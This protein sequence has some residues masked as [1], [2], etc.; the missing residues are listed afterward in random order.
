MSI[1]DPLRGK[2]GGQS[3]QNREGFFLG[4]NACLRQLLVN[5]AL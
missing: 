2:G 5:R 4:D 3:E 1:W